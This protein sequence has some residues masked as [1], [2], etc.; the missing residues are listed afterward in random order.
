M[1]RKEAIEISIIVWEE[2]ARTG[3]S[4]KS[5]LLDEIY[6]L[7]ENHKWNC[8]LCELYFGEKDCKKDCPLQFDDACDGESNFSMWCNSSCEEERKTYA[9]NIVDILK[10]ALKE[11]DKPICSIC[12]KPCYYISV[13]TSANP[14]YSNSVEVSNC[15]KGEVLDTAIE[16]KESNLGDV[17]QRTIEYLKDLVSRIESKEITPITLPSIQYS[18][19]TNDEGKPLEETLNIWFRRLNLV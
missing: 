7:I 13:N 14:L 11:Y 9:Q 19:L 17:E 4:N 10:E 18:S 8:S 3:I 6:D 5:N 15:C 2:L 12:N 1:N 16:S